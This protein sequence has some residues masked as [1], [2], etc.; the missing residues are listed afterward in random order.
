MSDDERTSIPKT[1]DVPSVD[2]L[3]KKKMTPI[4]KN[5][6]LAQPDVVPEPKVEPKVEPV[7]A[8]VKSD[9]KPSDQAKSSDYEKREAKPSDQAKSS[10]YE[11]R[12]A[13]PSDQAKSSD[14]ERRE[15]KPSDYERR[16]V[17]SSDY[18]RREAKPSDYERREAKSYIKPSA[19]QPVKPVS[20]DDSDY[21]ESNTPPPT[22]GNSNI[23]TTLECQGCYNCNWTGYS[24]DDPQRCK[25]YD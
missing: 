22:T 15:A 8:Y 4:M 14:Y 5:A 25:R 17:K 6:M 12:E 1:P 24:T 9:A 7:K 11:R 23:S 10:D 16:E 3:N 2:K 20:E 21:E 13:K 18:E 19:K